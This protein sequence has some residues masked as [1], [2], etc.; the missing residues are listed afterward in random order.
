MFPR[1]SRFP[2]VKVPD[3]PG[4]NSYNPQDPNTTHTSAERF[5]RR[6]TAS[7]RTSHPTSRTWR[8]QHR[9][10]HAQHEPS[11]TGPKPSANDRYAALQRK[12]EELERVHAE[13]KK[14]HHQEQERLKLALARAQRAAADDAERADKLKKHA[15]A[16]DARVQDL[17]KAGATD[18]TDLRDLRTRLRAAEQAAAKQADTAEAR[19]AEGKRR[20]ERERRVAELEK[21][22]GAEKKRREAAEEA[23]ARADGEAQNVQEALEEARAESQGARDALDELR[24][25]EDALVE[26]LEQHRA[27]LT[28][29]AQ[30]YGRLAAASVAEAKYTRAKER[31]VELA[32]LVRYTKDENVLLST[33]LRE[34]DADAHSTPWHYGRM[35]DGKTW[36]RPPYARWRR[37]W[38]LSAAI[39]VKRRPSRSTHSVQTHSFGVTFTDSEATL[40]CSTARG[41]SRVSTMRNVKHSSLLYSYPKPKQST[42][43]SS[44]RWSTPSRACGHSDA[45][46]RH[47][48]LT[49]DIQGRR[50]QP[51]EAAR[52]AACTVQ[53]DVAKVEH[54]LQKEKE[55]TQRL[56]ETVQK[57][58]AAE[59]AMQAEVEELT[60]EL[61]LAERYQEAYNSLVEEVDAL[62]DGMRS[63]KRSS[64]PTKIQRRIIGHN[65]PAQRIMYVDRIRSEL[66]ET[67]QKLLM[68]TRERDTAVADGDD[69]RYELQLYKS[70]AIPPELKPRTTVT[71]VG[72]V[73]LAT[74]SATSNGTLSTLSSVQ[75]LEC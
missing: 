22:L 39:L 29:V 1:G 54:M 24:T 37:M 44:R 61:S 46:H 14:T 32:N 40:C 48:S 31:V 16:L 56:A 6:R 69:L 45:A 2:A 25:R 41:S 21:T 62:I 58:R 26:Q 18:Q 35:L 55:T 34:A 59:E 3:V 38:S 57:C 42:P 10:N 17:K 67:K 5:S 68:L 52:R 4:P 27:L 72:R 11:T 33:R 53:A 8:I 60:S 70:V 64:A 19:R 43:T 30:E 65:N 63:R 13:S 71:R 28:R 74:Q 36:T 20:E 47:N 9:H 75:K 51:A 7:R 23:K 73:P 66:H 50:S 15:D 12:V 49:R